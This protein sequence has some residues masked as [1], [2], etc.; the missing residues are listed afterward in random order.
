MSESQSEINDEKF[1]VVTPVKMFKCRYAVEYQSS[2]TEDKRDLLVLMEN[3][4]SAGATQDDATIKSLL[5]RTG[6]GYRRITVIN[7]T[8]V[9]SFKS[10]VKGES[11][12]D[13]ICVEDVAHFSS[14]NLDEISEELKL[15]KDQTFDL[16]VASGALNNE[17]DPLRSELQKNYITIMNKIMNESKP[18]KLYVMKLV[19]NGEY[20]TR[21]DG[22]F[23][24]V[25][26]ATEVE[27]HNSTLV[28]V[29]HKE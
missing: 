18:S 25:E 23:G 5:H 12:P 4:S 27:W 2:D 7:I 20:G 29:V 13:D 19:G 8:P 10:I 11:I 21:F 22:Y 26:K 14:R 17:K 3:P 1:K 16:V 15:L 28:E 24:S 9:V 6:D